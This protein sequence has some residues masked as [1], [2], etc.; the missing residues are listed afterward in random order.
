M[1]AGGRPSAPWQVAH[2]DWNTARPSV[3]SLL[4][5]PLQAATAA[6]ISTHDFTP[7]MCHR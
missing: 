3:A 6:Q 4:G 5:P 1:A 7:A 2:S